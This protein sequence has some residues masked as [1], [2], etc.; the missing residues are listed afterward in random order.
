[1][2]TKHNCD[3]NETDSHHHACTLACLFSII[4]ILI[5]LKIFPESKMKIYR[6]G[7][8]RFYL[9][10]KRV[11]FTI[12]YSFSSTDSW[13]FNP[14]R[15]NSGMKRR[16]GCLWKLKNRRLLFDFNF[17][18]TVCIHWFER[19]HKLFFCGEKLVDIGYLFSNII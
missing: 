6:H 12:R 4:N 19:Y 17:P 10:K 1:M 7:L 15:K 13:S 9:R 14:L 16:K 8:E 2:L 11:Y 18:F 3:R 5:N